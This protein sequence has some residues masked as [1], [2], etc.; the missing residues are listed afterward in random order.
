MAHSDPD[1]VLCAYITGVAWR[2]AGSGLQAAKQRFAAVEELREVAGGRADLL[3][4]CAGIAIGSGESKLDRAWHRRMADLCV[5]A[6]ADEEL[7]PD[8]IGV[9]RSR[10]EYAAP[11]H[12]VGGRLGR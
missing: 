5:A 9:G 12:S 4:E 3:A 1:R 6:G 10:A 8:W 11:L 7:I 2:L